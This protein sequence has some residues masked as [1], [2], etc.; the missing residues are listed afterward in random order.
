MKRNAESVLQ[1]S[2]AIVKN[3]MVGIFLIHNDYIASECNK[4][5]FSRSLGTVTKMHFPFT[6]YGA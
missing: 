5:C 2:V 4:L 1:A 6:S 3:H